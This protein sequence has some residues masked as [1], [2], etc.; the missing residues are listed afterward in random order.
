[1]GCKVRKTNDINNN[2]L[3]T[4]KT[5]ENRTKSS[6]DIKTGRKINNLTGTNCEKCKKRISS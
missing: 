2:T 3:I 6:Y 5:A 1:M 4:L